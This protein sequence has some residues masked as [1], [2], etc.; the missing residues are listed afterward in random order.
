MMSRS[1]SSDVQVMSRCRVQVMPRSYPCHVQVM[2]RSC[3]GRVQV[4][5][6]SDVQV[7]CK[8]RFQVMSK[9][10][11]GHVF[12]FG[13]H[14]M[15]E[16]NSTVCLCKPGQEH[17]TQETESSGKWRMSRSC[18]GHVEVMSKSCPGHVQVMSR[19]CPIHV[20]VVSKS[21]PSVVSMC[22]VQVSCPC[23]VSKSCP[24]RVQVVFARC[25]DPTTSCVLCPPTFRWTT[26]F[27]FPVVSHSCVAPC[28][29]CV[30]IWTC[31]TGRTSI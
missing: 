31:V 9:S 8:C 21:C 16:G 24:S 10:Y 25:W 27:Q 7:M 14:E 30:L 26:Y 18:P 20:Q 11:L 15:R 23:V 28:F 5:C 29:R 2:P 4:S 22:R 6:P 12:F 13:T 19:S 1:C 3:P 17:L